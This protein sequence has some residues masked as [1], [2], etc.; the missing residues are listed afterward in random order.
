MSKTRAWEI[1]AVLVV[2]LSLIIIFIPRGNAIE[3]HVR[4]AVKYYQEGNYEEAILAFDKAITIDDK[5][6][7]LHYAKA[8]AQ[9]ATGDEDGAMTSVYRALLLRRDGAGDTQVAVLYASLMEGVAHKSEKE[10]VYMWYEKNRDNEELSEFASWVKGYLNEL[11]VADARK[12]ETIQAVVE[13]FTASL[14]KLE[15]F[16][17]QRRFVSL[18]EYKEDRSHIGLADLEIGDGLMT[19][20][21]GDFD[22]DGN[23][24]FLTLEKKAD[25]LWVRL[26]RVGTDKVVSLAEKNIGS[27]FREILLQDMMKVYINQHKGI[28]YVFFEASRCGGLVSQGSGQWDFLACNLSDGRLT[29]VCNVH[30]D[31]TYDDDTEALVLKHLRDFGLASVYDDMEEEYIDITIYLNHEFLNFGGEDESSDLMFRGSQG[32]LD[33]TIDFD[34]HIHAPEHIPPFE[35]SWYIIDG[36]PLDTAAQIE[37]IDTK[38]QI[39]SVQEKMDAFL[40]GMPKVNSFSDTRA[41][42]AKDKPSYEGDVLKL[43]S[44]TLA[45]GILSYRTGDFDSDGNTEILAV[46]SEENHI[47]IRLYRVEDEVNLIAE[48]EVAYLMDGNDA[49]GIQRVAVFTKTFNNKMYVFCENDSYGYWGASGGEYTIAGYCVS[50]SALSEDLYELYNEYGRSNGSFDWIGVGADGSIKI[51]KIFMRACFF[52]TQ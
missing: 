6:P 39:D 41:F 44:Y 10:W 28:S 43:A 29:D 21:T 11:E 48:K 46:V 23:T 45:N 5:I 2:V 8:E 13:A 20:R 49:I 42:V 37:A 4:L 47:L 33:P 14:P 34:G 15:S 27:F 18:G 22:N 12:N 25:D 35:I 31:N 36:A 9:M 26:Y 19:Y 7:T 32:Y 50:D 24:E 51:K 38:A 30:Y 3:R 40:A 52:N 1:A 17:G 16:Q